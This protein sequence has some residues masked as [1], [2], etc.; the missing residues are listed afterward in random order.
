MGAIFGPGVMI[1]WAMVV[2][3]F[4]VA[5]RQPGARHRLGA[6]RGAD[7]FLVNGP[8]IC[9]AIL[10]AGF[11]SP[12]LPQDMVA[13]WLGEGAG[14]Q[15][16]VIGCVVGPFFPGG[17]LIIMPLMLA[18]LKAGAGVPA[19]IALLTAS[20]T[21]GLHRI[22]MFEIPMMGARFTG[23]RLVSSIAIPPLAGLLAALLVEVLGA[24]APGR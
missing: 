10:A 15:G 23:L 14:W 19:L 9:V 20:S 11:I 7:M 8:R 3:A 13:E 22:F 1:I 16:I 24:P 17:P 12:I 21:W 5:V 18:L 2:V 4:V 6:M